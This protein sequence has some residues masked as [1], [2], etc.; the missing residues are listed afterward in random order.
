MNFVDRQKQ[1]IHFQPISRSICHPGTYLSQSAPDPPPRRLFLCVVFAPRAADSK[2]AA[3]RI[4]EFRE[5]INIEPRERVII[6][7]E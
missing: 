6:A 2:A 5:Y 3:S 7:A 1:Y 4:N